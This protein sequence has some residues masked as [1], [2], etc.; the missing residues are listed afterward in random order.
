MAQD[1]TSVAFADALSDI[2]DTPSLKNRIEGWVEDF[3][4][5]RMYGFIRH[6]PGNGIFFMFSD[7]IPDVVGRYFLK[8]GTPVSFELVKNRG[9]F[10]ASNVKDESPELLEIDLDNY[11]ETS[12]VAD[13]RGG[14]GFLSRPS[15][16]RLY[17]HRNKIITV[18]QELLK[19]W[20]GVDDPCWVTHKIGSA[21]DSTGRKKFF[22]TDVQILEPAEPSL[23]EIFLKS[24]E[25]PIDV[26]EPVAAPQ[27][28]VLSSATRNLTLLEIRQRREGK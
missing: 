18:G 10:R 11:R 2:G 26:P 24:P 15:G 6:E 8:P 3:Y 16:E 7:V 20:D 14:Y 13:W 4:P 27:S 19:S 21:T 9:R 28:S 1:Y 23:E 5:K 12:Y 17:F 22:A 25:L